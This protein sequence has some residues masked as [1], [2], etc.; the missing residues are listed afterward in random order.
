MAATISE[1]EFHEILERFEAYLPVDVEEG[2][3]DECGGF[4]SY[5]GLLDEDTCP[6]P[7]STPCATECL[8][9]LEADPPAT[10]DEPGGT[11]ELL[12]D[13]VGQGPLPTGGGVHGR[14]RRCPT[15]RGG[16]FTQ[17]AFAY[18]HGGM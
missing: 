16:H 2:V 11:L 6:A 4:L 3:G 9:P 10:N 18:V 12:A 8:S 17:H 1:D 13:L 15:E 5:D 14:R 7:P